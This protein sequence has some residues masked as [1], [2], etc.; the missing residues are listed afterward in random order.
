MPQSTGTL[1]N[2]FEPP[3]VFQA[4]SNTDAHLLATLEFGEGMY[5]LDKIH[6]GLYTASKK[7]EFTEE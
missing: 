1:E 2:E 5:D 3:F 6:D 7:I 4:D